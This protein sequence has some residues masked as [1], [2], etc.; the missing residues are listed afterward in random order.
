MN[1][2][3][4]FYT[5]DRRPRFAE[6]PTTQPVYSPA[7]EAPFVDSGESDTAASDGDTPQDNDQQE[8]HPFAISAK[9]TELGLSGEATKVR[10]KVLGGTYATG[11]GSPFVV[12]GGDYPSVVL[13]ETQSR[14]GYK[15]VVLLFVPVE[16]C[17]EG[18]AG[19][20]K[21]HD[22]KFARAKAGGFVATSTFVP[23]AFPTRIFSPTVGQAGFF[24][25]VGTWTSSF[26]EQDVGGTPTRENRLNRQQLVLNDVVLDAAAD[27][28]GL[29][30]GE[31]GDML[32]HDGDK[33][34]VLP[35]PTGFT[36]NP[37]LRHNGTAP[38]WEEPTACP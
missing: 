23:A 24:V 19:A 12:S 13:D 15:G 7:P 38:Y 6:T 33:W 17:E 28:E 18:D 21:C 30:E 11:N 37:V 31:E 20:V 8:D 3:D 36:Q 9:V 35:K 25:H 34:V 1:S 10:V 16:P 32:Y 26:A 2:D 29:P 22:G 14:G 4:P 27:T 5:F